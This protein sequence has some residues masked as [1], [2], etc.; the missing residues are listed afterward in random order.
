MQVPLTWYVRVIIAEIWREAILG[1]SAGKKAVEEDDA[2]NVV[3]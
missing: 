1:L 2:K 3:F